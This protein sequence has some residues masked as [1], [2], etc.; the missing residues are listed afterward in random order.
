MR[1]STIVAKIEDRAVAAYAQ[2]LPVAQAKAVSLRE[3]IALQR[4]ALIA[5]AA[6]YRAAAK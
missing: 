3:R 1:I 5:A 6:A 4:N 2:A